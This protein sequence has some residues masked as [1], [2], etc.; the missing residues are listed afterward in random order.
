VIFKISLNL[1][2]IRDSG[3][4]CNVIRKKEATLLF[5]IAYFSPRSGT[6]G[7]K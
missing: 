2:N 7:T 5:N 3:S 1:E 4:K 6:R